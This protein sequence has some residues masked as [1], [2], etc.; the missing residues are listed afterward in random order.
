[1]MVAMKV[2]QRVEQ[3][4]VRWVAEKAGWLAAL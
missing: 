2:E 3:M 1:M 4:A